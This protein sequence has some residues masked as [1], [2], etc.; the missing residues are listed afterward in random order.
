MFKQRQCGEI[1]TIRILF[2]IKE[3]IVSFDL[4][5]VELSQIIQY[6]HF[7]I[8]TSIYILKTESRNV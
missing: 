6:F 7:L 5:K 1:V 8:K 2:E 3:S 4:R